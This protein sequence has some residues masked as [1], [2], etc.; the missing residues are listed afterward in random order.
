MARSEKSSK[1][2]P[3]RLS[4]VASRMAGLATPSSKRTRAPTPRKKCADVKT[5]DRWRVVTAYLELCK[6]RDRLPRGSMAS[7]KARFPHLNLTART[8]QRIVDL[9]KTQ[10]MDAEAAGKVRLTRRRASLCGGQNI[11]L[12]EELAKKLIE[13]NDKHWGKL[14]CKKLAGELT[15]AGFPSSTSSVKRWCKT[16]GATRRRRYIKPLLSPKHRHDRL[17]WAIEHYEKSRRKF[18][19]NNI[20][21]G[22]EK[23]FYLMR[24]GTVCRVF[25]QNVANEDGVVE[26][27]VNMAADPRVYH[28]SRMP[29]VMFWQSQLSRVMRTSSMAKSVSGHS[30]YS[31][32]P[33]AATR[34]QELSLAKLTSSR[35]SH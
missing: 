26:Q 13:I 9:Y 21:H 32:K 15:C 30:H 19:D 4:R 2:K 20:C 8:V 14:S 28:K 25:P 17:S 29:K 1:K 31:E 6:G 5:P 23:W 22:D 33:S 11:V 34:K 24:D 16:L 35:V 12:T 7:L 27:V 10:T 18:V 3:P